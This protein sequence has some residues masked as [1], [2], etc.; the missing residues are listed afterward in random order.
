MAKIHFDGSDAAVSQ[1][2]VACM[3]MHLRKSSTA[4]GAIIETADANGEWEEL[5]K[6]GGVLLMKGTDITIYYP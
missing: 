2:R 3:G 5:I 4:D 1:V 6:P